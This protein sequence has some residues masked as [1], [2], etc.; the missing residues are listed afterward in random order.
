M[1]VLYFR[2]ATSEVLP[3]GCG[4]LVPA[5]MCAHGVV[6]RRYLRAI[7]LYAR[8]SLAGGARARNSVKSLMVELCAKHMA[9]RC[10]SESV[11]SK[12]RSAKQVQAQRKHQRAALR[13]YRGGSV[14]LYTVLQ[15][16]E[17]CMSLSLALAI[18]CWEDVTAICG[19]QNDISPDYRASGDV[20]SLRFD[21]EMPK[22]RWTRAGRGS[23][24]IL[25]RSLLFLLQ[26]SLEF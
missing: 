6:T 20:L 24:R 22:D 19:R 2:P 16:A 11:T 13:D 5:R 17:R 15:S 12:E 9:L 14:C 4:D 25:F 18:E 21:L 23:A 26:T 10:V 1:E 3:G 8:A 7:V